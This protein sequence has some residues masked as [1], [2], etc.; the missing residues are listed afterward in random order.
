MI[1]IDMHKG[2]V[3]LERLK[4]VES[5]MGLFFPKSYVNF[6]LPNDGC[7]TDPDGFIFFD[8]SFQ[9]EVGSCIGSFMQLKPDLDYF[10]DILS[11]NQKLPEFFPKGLVQFGHVGN[12][13]Y[14]CFDYRKGKD[15]LDPP[16]VYWNHE[17][18]EGKDV[19]FLANNFDAFLKILKTDEEM[20]ALLK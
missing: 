11:M 20:D 9:E 2:L 7:R 16:I 4:Y 6:V 13:D 5:E 17:A 10:E 8:E 18:E 14:I 12:G 3:N 1:K 19:S 15:N